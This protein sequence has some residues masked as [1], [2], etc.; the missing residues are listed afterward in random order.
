MPKVF[1]GVPWT[2]FL[3]NN[4]EIGLNRFEKFETTAFF[5]NARFKWGFLKNP[6][7]IQ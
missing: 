4:I 6:R 5:E 2:H 1:V 7:Q 3:K